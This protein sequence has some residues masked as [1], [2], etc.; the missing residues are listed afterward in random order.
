MSSVLV[1]EE[2]FADLPDP[3]REHAR[4]HALLDVLAIALCAVLSGAEGFVDMA[5]FGQARRDWLHER[6]GLSLEGGIPSHDTFGRVFALLD[7]GAFSR[8]FL[9]W[10]QALH[11]ATQGR[12]VALDG[13]TV[14]RSFDAASGQAALHLV[15]AWAGESRL[16]LGQV[17]VDGK[18]N[19]ITAL[20]ALLSLLDLSGSTV[21]IDAMG[22][23]TEI[24]AQV[25]AQ[26]GDYAL[27]LTPIKSQGQP[28]DAVGGHG[29]PVR[30][31]GGDRRGERRAGRARV[32]LVR[33]A[34]EGPRAHRDAPL[35]P[36]LG[37]AGGGALAGPRV[38]VGGPAGGGH[39]RV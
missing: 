33:G 21:A 3:R 29:P 35:L 15:S 11:E 20:P 10:T 24:A 19:E 12:A 7:P 13:K 32:P 2:C 4:R 28:P 36:H 31:A 14:R 26:G 27:A 39:G 8:C 16:A 25:T 38:Q 23:Q 1:L 30:A 22:C 17:A 34:G 5:R 37:A 6:L 9:A 18:S